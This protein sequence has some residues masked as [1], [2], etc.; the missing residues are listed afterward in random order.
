M[1]GDFDKTFGAGFKEKLTAALLAVDD[2]KM[3]A[4]FDRTKF[5]PTKN[6]NYKV[7]ETVGK[8]TGLL[9]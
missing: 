3:L 8:L 1:R 4:V 2:P 6:E 5:I 7:I 9:N